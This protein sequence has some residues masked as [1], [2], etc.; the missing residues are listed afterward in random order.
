MDTVLKKILWKKNLTAPNPKI[1]YIYG[2]VILVFKGNF[3]NKKLIK[4]MFL[5]RD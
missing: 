3:F 4:K 1:L 2:G 5:Q